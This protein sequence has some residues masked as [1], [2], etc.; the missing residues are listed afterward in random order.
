MLQ[1]T[2]VY[3]ALNDDDND[4]SKYRTVRLIS[5]RPETVWD[6]PDQRFLFEHRLN[7]IGLELAKVFLQA[8]TEFS[9]TFDARQMIL[10]Y[11]F[12]TFVRRLSY[13]PMI[14]Q[15]TLE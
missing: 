12:P 9:F 13:Y 5:S 14:L 10:R 3:K 1:I 6:K 11:A 8:D 4:A 15:E 7:V 2:H